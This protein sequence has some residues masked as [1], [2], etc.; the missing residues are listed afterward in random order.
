[1]LFASG[2][3]GNLLDRLIYSGVRDFIDFHVWPVFNMADVFLTCAVL[4][5]LW[6]EYL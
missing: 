1:M 5:L 2:A 3:A 4:V 6:V